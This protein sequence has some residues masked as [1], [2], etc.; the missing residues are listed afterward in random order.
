MSITVPTGYVATSP[1]RSASLVFG[2]PKIVNFGV[3][4]ATPT[5]TPTETPTR[6]HDTP[7]QTPTERPTVTPTPDDE[8]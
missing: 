7:T 4:A 2:V 6:G 1:I 8:H 3:R 5:P